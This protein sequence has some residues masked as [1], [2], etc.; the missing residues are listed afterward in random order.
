M[1]SAAM[2]AIVLICVLVLPIVY[3]FGLPQYHC[4]LIGS[5][6]FGLGAVTAL[7]LLFAPK[8]MTVY[9]P[10][11]SIKSSKIA[12]I[13]AALKAS[14]KKGT[15][16]ET[17]DGTQTFHDSARMLK[18][19]SHEQRLL[20]CQEQMSGWQA[21]LL[22]NQAHAMDTSDSHSQSHSHSHSQSQSA[23]GGVRES[24]YELPSREVIASSQLQPDWDV[25]RPV[26]KELTLF[27]ANGSRSLQPLTISTT[28][29][30]D[31]E[32]QDA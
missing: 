19:K 7:V 12:A 15:G 18:G 25:Y 20:I 8:M 30:H 28:T 31:L 22:R 13:D 26:G 23:G 24:G 2:S 14:S 16:D 9:T 1:H 32:M 11:L 6:G 3:L 29:G 17:Q 27:H 4:E 10:A 5:L 21:L